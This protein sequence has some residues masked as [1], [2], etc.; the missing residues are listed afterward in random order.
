MIKLADAAAQVLALSL[1][2]AFAGSAIAQQDFPNKPI[3]ILVSSTPGGSSDLSARLIGQKLTES[4]GQ[5][6]IVDNRPGANSIIAAEALAKST[7]DGHTTMLVQLAHIIN[8]LVVPNLPFDAIRDFAPVATITNSRYVLTVNFSIPANSLKEFIA[9]AKSRPG[10]L[11]YA[12]S[13]TASAAHLTTEILSSMVGITMQHIPYKGPTQILNDLA[14]GQLQVYLATALSTLPYIKA[15][16]IRAIAISGDTRL[17]ALPEV[18][19]F[20]EAGVP[21]FDM[22]NWYGFIAPGATPRPVINKMSAEIAKILTMPD[23][24]AKLASQGGEPFITTPEQFAELMK[25]D[26][27]RFARI[28]K[29]ANIKIEK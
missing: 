17:P 8:P 7:P 2:A 4:W 18:P 1:L 19:T 25:A 24:V 26:M 23:T 14:G 29:A 11:N 27:A 20:A 5:P 6:V 22:K 12:S 28:I 3:H 21:G 9:Y 10:Q 16:R 15:G 13:G